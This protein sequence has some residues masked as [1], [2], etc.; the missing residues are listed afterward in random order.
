MDKSPAAMVPFVREH[1]HPLEIIPFFRRFPYSFGRDFLYTFIWSGLIGVVFYVLNSM[2]AGRLGSFRAFG[3]YI[4]IANV[5]G[6]AIH[7]LFHVGSALAL[8]TAARRAGFAAKVIYFSLIPLL[9]V[10]IG[11]WIISMPGSSRP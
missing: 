6:Y 5:I 11:F 7:V 10:F 9:G 3:L 1:F 4:L 8:D 2:G